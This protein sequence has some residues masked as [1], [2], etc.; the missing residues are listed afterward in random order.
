LRE[1][2]EE[3]GIRQEHVDVLGELDEFPTVTRFKINPFVGVI[4]YPYS[5][6]PNE[7]EVSQL[8]QAPLSAFVAPGVLTT[9]QAPIP[10]LGRYRTIYSYQIGLHRVWGATA[11][12]LKELLDI[13]SVLQSGMT[14]RS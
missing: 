4:P 13:I 5:F 1:A 6:V 7:R 3:V 2:F 8:I 9:Q 11:A 10:F 12:I 14:A